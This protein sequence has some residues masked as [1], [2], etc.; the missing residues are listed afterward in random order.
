MKSAPGIISGRL[1]VGNIGI[2]FKRKSS[3]PVLKE[4]LSSGESVQSEPA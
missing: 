3:S 4:P 1:V 2:T